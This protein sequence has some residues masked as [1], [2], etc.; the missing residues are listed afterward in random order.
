M[1][2]SVGQ[3]QLPIFCEFA[4]VSCAG[5]SSICSETRLSKN[6]FDFLRILFMA[7]WRKHPQKTWGFCWPFHL[8]I[9]VTKPCENLC[10][11]VIDRCQVPSMTSTNNS[12]LTS[13]SRAVHIIWL[14]CQNILLDNCYCPHY[15]SKGLQ[16]LWPASQTHLCWSLTL[17]CN[18]NRL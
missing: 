5:V 9:S 3:K 13:E 16:P 10:P 17:K 4:M 12:I 6:H 11:V 2:I 8:P 7:R 1:N 15:Y 18:G 14:S